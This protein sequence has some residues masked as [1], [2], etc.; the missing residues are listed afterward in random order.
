MKELPEV[1][2]TWSSNTVV[3]RA[4]GERQWSR[5]RSLA[6]LGQQGV[7]LL[8]ARRVLLT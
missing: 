3:R 8:R 7:Q 5:L 1:S 2:T 4:V 6:V